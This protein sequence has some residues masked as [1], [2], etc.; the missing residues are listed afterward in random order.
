MPSLPQNGNYT[1]T[2]TSTTTTI[3]PVENTTTTT[4]TLAPCALN[5]DN[6]SIKWLVHNDSIEQSILENASIKNIGNDCAGYWRCGNISRISNTNNNSSHQ[7]DLFLDTN[8]K[9]KVTY[10]VQSCVGNSLDFGQ[11]VVEIYKIENDVKTVYVRELLSASTPSELV[12]RAN[13][14][15]THNGQLHSWIV[16]SY[17]DE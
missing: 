3:A 1:T 7:S 8:F 12:Q 13:G 15:F 11:L 17:V 9:I 10:V 5:L 14:Q 4:T 2:T 6:F 16:E